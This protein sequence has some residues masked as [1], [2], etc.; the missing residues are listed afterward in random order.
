MGIASCD[1]Q[2]V[3]QYDPVVILKLMCEIE[4]ASIPLRTS[5][6]VPPIIFNEPT[7]QPL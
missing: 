7:M 4:Y 3:G 2:A 1:Q 5:F 6:L